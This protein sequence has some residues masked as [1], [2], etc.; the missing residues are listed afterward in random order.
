M[1]AGG[2]VRGLIA[3]AL[4]AGA[5]AAAAPDR[6]E[7]EADA[8]QRDLRDRAAE[9]DRITRREDTALQALETAARNLDRQRR[10]ARVSREELEEIDRRID[11]IRAAEEDLL[12][13][14]RAGRRY[15]SGRLVALYKAERLEEGEGPAFASSIHEA[16]TR[17][18]ALRRI[19]ERD[20]RALVE[21]RDHEVELA[22]LQAELAERRGRQLALAAEYDRRLAA[23]GRERSA[24][25]RAL[26]R[27]QGDRAAQ[28]AAIESLQAAARELDRQIQALGSASAPRPEGA[29]AGRPLAELKGL[30][31]FPV[32]GKIVSVFGPYRDPQSK[33]PAFRN[34]IE[35]A[36]ERGE[37][38]RAVHAG[39]VAFAG[40]FR[41]YGNVLIIDHGDHFH[42][43]YAHLEETFKSVDNRVEAG[44]VVAT[45]G[46]SG[47]M[48]GAG[49]YFELRHRDRAVDPLA[50]LRP[51]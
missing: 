39:S 23:V 1:L 9:V 19:L 36:A 43:V 42:S 45:A 14:T 40:W 21:L 30:L 10:D 25:E 18:A 3:A 27:L 20:R 31:I 51:D 29:S 15:L 7:Q 2:V 46:D 26:Q 47:P 48:G 24:R 32:D 8:V 16:V 4:F 37:P 13:R 44:E 11:A 50:W 33:T 38:V 41:G 22:R 49:L 34:G 12:A 6:L 5:A 17:R 35:I 28:L